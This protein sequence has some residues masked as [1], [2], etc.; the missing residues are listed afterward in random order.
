[1]VGWSPQKKRRNKHTCHTHLLARCVGG[2][3]RSSPR[4]LF[5]SK[6][7]GRKRKRVAGG[8]AAVGRRFFFSGLF[9]EGGWGHSSVGVG[10]GGGG[11][12]F[13]LFF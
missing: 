1:M 11:G 3:A 13:I 4:L 8:G 10:R 12:I 7:P 9:F 5:G 6:R 2:K